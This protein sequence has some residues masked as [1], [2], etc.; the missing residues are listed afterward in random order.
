MD[1]GRRSF[2]KVSLGIGGFWAIAPTLSCA[3]YHEASESESGNRLSFWLESGGGQKEGLTFISSQCEMGQGIVH[4]LAKIFCEEFS[5]PLERLQISFAPV[6]TEYRN[7][8]FGVQATGGSTSIIGFYEPLRKAGEASR[9]ILLKTAAAKWNIP[10][11][12]NS[13]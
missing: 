13:K 12:N 1:Q 10:E 3:T 5:Y 7:P 6:A 9:H 8:A 4:S 11:T 2:L